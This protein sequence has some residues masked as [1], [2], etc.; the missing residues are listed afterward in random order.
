MS[1]TKYD[2]A[3]GPSMPMVT[4]F[5]CANASFDANTPPAPASRNCRR[6]GMG[7][8]PEAMYS[9]LGFNGRPDRTRDAG[10][11]QAAVAARVLAEVLLVIVLGVVVRRRLADLGGNRAPALLL[12]SLL[13]SLLRILRGLELLRA[14]GV[15]GR[16]VLR[17]RIVTL[18]HALRRVVAF[19]EHLEELLVR[20]L[21]RVQDDMDDFGMVGEPAANF[22]V[23]WIL[24]LP[25][26]VADRRRVHAG[27][28]PEE[29]LRAPE[30][31]QAEDRLLHAFRERRLA[32]MA[33]D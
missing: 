16:A 22:L 21:L 6:F 14:V 18:A 25:A 24:R 29:A 32:R 27:Q 1:G 10:A 17:A 23:G 33:V 15:D 9:G 2:C 11:A 20:D 5:A 4:G 12:Q 28:L 13:V 30:A 8:P 7:P 3:R 26:G 31:A 19:P